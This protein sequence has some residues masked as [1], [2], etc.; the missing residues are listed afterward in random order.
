M[1]T[2]PKQNAKRKLPGTYNTHAKANFPKVD[3]K[4]KK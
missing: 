3:N 4:R 1:D 2:A